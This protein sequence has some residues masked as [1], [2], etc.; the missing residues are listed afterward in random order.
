MND[1]LPSWKGHPNSL[2]DSRTV[3]F[4]GYLDSSLGLWSNTAGSYHTFYGI[5]IQVPEETVKSTLI[6]SS[7]R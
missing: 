3:C 7:P 5:A 6:I 1:G 2:D 4:C